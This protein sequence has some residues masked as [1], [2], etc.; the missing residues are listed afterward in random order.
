MPLSTQ[1][2]KLA[3]GEREYVAWAVQNKLDSGSSYYVRIKD[4]PKAILFGPFAECDDA[5][6]YILNLQ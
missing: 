6:V 2:L 1:G 4:V 3:V 5:E